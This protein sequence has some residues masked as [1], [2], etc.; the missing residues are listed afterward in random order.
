MSVP[1]LNL[2][3]PIS[4]E[5]VD[6]ATPEGMEEFVL[7]VISVELRESSTEQAL[8][9]SVV[10]SKAVTI[11]DNDGRLCILVWLEPTSYSIFLSN[12]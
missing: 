11:H 5:I 1:L 8:E 7:E 12:V 2:P 3:I 6:D 4:F 10:D 9:V